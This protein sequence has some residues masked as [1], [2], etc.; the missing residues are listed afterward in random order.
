MAELRDLVAGLGCRD[1]RSYIASGNLVFRAARSEAIGPA[2][3]A[4]IAE[5]WGHEVSVMIRS[6]GELRRS[7]AACP[8]SEGDGARYVGFCLGEPDPGRL[9]PDRSPPDRW[10]VVGREVHLVYPN[11]RADSTL[12]AAY[13]ESALGIPVTVRN[14]RT[15][16]R[17]I[18]MLD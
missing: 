17:L 18:E 3:A 11:G 12:T 4:A 13:V 9:D 10:A 5:R 1:V 14:W 15:F 16:T 8:F 2:I 6:G 7:E